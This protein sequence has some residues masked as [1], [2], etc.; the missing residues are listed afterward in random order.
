[1]EDGRLHLHPRRIQRRLGERRQ[2]LA[3]FSEQLSRTVKS[4]LDRER[5]SLARLAATVTAQNPEASLRKGYCIAVKEGRAVH[6][7]KELAKGDRLGLKMRDGR[8]EVRVEEVIYDE[9]V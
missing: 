6:S 3:D 8:G 7:A 4:R 9:D 1:L 5:L 2:E